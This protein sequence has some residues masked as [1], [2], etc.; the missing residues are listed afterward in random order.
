MEKKTMAEEGV[1]TVVVDGN[2]AP[3]AGAQATPA[4]PAAGDGR[5]AQAPATPPADPEA[6]A[7]AAAAEGSKKSTGPDAKGDQS[8]E[9]TTGE[10]SIQPPEGLEAFQS[11]YDSFNTEASTWLQENPA[12]TPADALKWAADRQSTLVQEQTTAAGAALVE[13]VGQWETA[14]KADREVGGANYEASFAAANKAVETW[15]S[16]DLRAELDKSGLGSHPEF[17][18]FAARAGKALTEAPVLNPGVPGGRKNFAKAVY[19]DS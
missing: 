4:A 12:A 15:G 6:V 1:T 9:P 3:D 11:Q 16:P 17:F 18:K 8:T 5:Q 19:G 7:A 10:I 14:I 2:Q 13:Q